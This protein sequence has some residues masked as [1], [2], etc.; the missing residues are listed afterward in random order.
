MS[1]I[2][3]LS[4]ADTPELAQKIATALVQADEAA[5]VNIVSGIRSIYRWEGKLCDEAEVLLLIKSTM[6]KFDAV[7]AR[8][9]EL[10][11]YQ[12]PEVIAIPIA[13]GDPAYLQWLRDNT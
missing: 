13:A 7:N 10:H 9:R 1:E 4:T 8:I 5:C 6:D 11:T 2:L 12:L 3:I